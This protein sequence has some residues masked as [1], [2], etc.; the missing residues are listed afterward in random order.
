MDTGKEEE[1]VRCMERVA[2][3]LRLP[4]KIDS[5][6]EFAVTQET[7]TG[8]LYQ[9]RGVQWGGRQEGGSKGMS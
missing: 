5:Q 1:R 3:K 9:S 4:Y 7:Q 8:A 6:W 2:W